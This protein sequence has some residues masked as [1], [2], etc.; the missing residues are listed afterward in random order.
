MEYKEFRAPTALRPVVYG[1]WLLRTDA[2]PA[3][4][5]RFRLFAE[6]CPGITFQRVER[7]APGSGAGR[8]YDACHIHGPSDRFSDHD[9]TGIGT[10]E[11]IGVSFLPHALNT[12]FGVPTMTLANRVEPVQAVLGPVGASLESGL[13]RCP[14]TTTR[15]HHLRNWILNRLAALGLEP[16]PLQRAIHAQIQSEG[17]CAI[18]ALIAA[19][20]LSR[21]QF[22]RRFQ[23]E[24]GMSPKVFARVLRFQGALRMGHIPVRSKLVDIA[25]DGGYYDQ[26][27]FVREFRVFA[28]MPPRDYYARRQGVALNFI[29]HCWHQTP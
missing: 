20:G 25:Q 26:S 7:L 29:D 22:E 23:F 1:F 16:D 15:L 19:S 18:G 27:H 10:L 12:L 28:G 6:A 13:S 24:T 3:N 4:Q 8:I 17:R 14:D 2:L 9:A 5:R 21:R 11:V